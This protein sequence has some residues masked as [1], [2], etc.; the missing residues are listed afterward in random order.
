METRT[1][2]IV[3]TT[4][5]IL[6]CGTLVQATPGDTDQCR[7]SAAV[8]AF[9]IKITKSGQSA[10]EAIT[11]TVGDTLKCEVSSFPAP[12]WTSW[13]SD[14][15]PEHVNSSLVTLD[16]IGTYEVSCNVHNT[17]QCA[18]H[19]AIKMITVTVN[20]PPPSTATP[21]GD[22]RSSD[23]QASDSSPAPK[24]I[25]SWIPLLLLVLG[26]SMTSEYC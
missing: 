10:S 11:V 21:V 17:F 5:L 18:Q 26:Y 23:R 20:P 19:A 7:I 8:T 3:Y 13:S 22:K 1:R 12:D 9:D 6:L 16:H 2:A 4:S 25:S 14:E 24:L 15:F